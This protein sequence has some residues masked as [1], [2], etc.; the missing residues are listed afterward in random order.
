MGALVVVALA[1]ALTVNSG[2]SIHLFLFLI[3]VNTR[4][5]STAIWQ[6]NANGSRVES[7]RFY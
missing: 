3:L 6:G 1:L 4:E 2:S 5:C 7:T